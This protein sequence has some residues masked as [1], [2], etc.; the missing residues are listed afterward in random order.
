MYN[1]SSFNFISYSQVSTLFPVSRISHGEHFAGYSANINTDCLSILTYADLL[2]H[3]I[4]FA[5]ITIRKIWFS[6]FGFQNYVEICESRGQTALT[7]LSVLGSQCSV[8]A[9]KF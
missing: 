4:A 7:K 6:F 1:I 3:C 8:C 5:N 2:L 9:C